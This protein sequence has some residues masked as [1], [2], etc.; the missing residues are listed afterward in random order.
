MSDEVADAFWVP[1]A[2]L[3]DPATRGTHLV[4]ARGARFKM[5][6]FAVGE[7]IIWGMTERILSQLLGLPLPPW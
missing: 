4:E 2:T 1:L 6:A 7:R 5:P 3:L